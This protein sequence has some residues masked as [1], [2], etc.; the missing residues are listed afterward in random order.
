M[1]IVV[2]PS[3]VCRCVLRLRERSVPLLS[4]QEDSLVHLNTL[5]FIQMKGTVCI[6]Y[7]L[8]A[9]PLDGSLLSAVILDL[10]LSGLGS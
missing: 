7:S 10:K 5:P 3:A 1:S 4:A 9:F 8:I 6:I 2:E